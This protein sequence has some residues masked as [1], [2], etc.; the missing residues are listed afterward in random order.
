[1]ALSSGNTLEISMHPIQFMFHY[2]YLDDFSRLVLQQQFKIAFP[3]VR[4]P[5][6]TLLMDG[7][8]KVI[9]LT[10]TYLAALLLLCPVEAVKTF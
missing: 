5:K 10:K 4:I 3:N 9:T 6:P 2:T 8:N 7:E 1:M